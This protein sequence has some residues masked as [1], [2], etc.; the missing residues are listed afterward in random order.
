MNKNAELQER[1]ESEGLNCVIYR[2]KWWERKHSEDLEKKHLS[3]DHPPG[4]CRKGSAD[5]SMTHFPLLQR[6]SGEK[7]CMW[8]LSLPDMRSLSAHHMHSIDLRSCAS[9]VCICIYM[10]FCIIRFQCVYTR[11]HLWFPQQSQKAVSND[12]PMYG[13]W[14]YQ[15]GHWLPP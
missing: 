15:C 12:Q 11:R 1:W 5:A 6:D 8:Y 7:G 4:S 3:P 10:N 2:F 9:G 14:M 13:K